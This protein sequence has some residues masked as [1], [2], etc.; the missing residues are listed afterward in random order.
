MREAKL[1]VPGLELTEEEILLN[2]QPFNQGSDAEQLRVSIAVAGALNPRLR[3]IRV[4][5]G[6][7]LDAKS[8]AALSEYAEEHDLQVWVETVASNRQTAVV[9][10]DGRVRS[11]SGGVA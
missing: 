4:R 10:E 7:L 8:M 5:D 11:I 1:P 2:G 3:V 6:S 9:I